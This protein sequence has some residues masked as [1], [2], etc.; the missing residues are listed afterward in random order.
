MKA[1]TK[2]SKKLEVV[3]EKFA[4]F[5][6]Y[7]KQLKSTKEYNIWS[8]LPPQSDVVTWLLTWATAPQLNF[9]KYSC[10]TIACRKIIVFYWFIVLQIQ[11]SIIK[12]NK[13]IP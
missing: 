8:S 10:I 11:L 7:R 9:Q 4:Q 6:P 12:F 5:L 3:D 2:A 1:F 13:S